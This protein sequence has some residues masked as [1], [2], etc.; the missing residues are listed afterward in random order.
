[1]NT[2]MI[3]TKTELKE[4]TIRIK[5]LKSH[6]K[7]DKRGNWKL[8]DLHY[9]I[10]NS[11]CTFRTKHIAYS[12]ARGRKYEEIEHNVRLGN[13]PNW[14]AINKLLEVLNEQE[15]VRACA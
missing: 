8:Y 14:H 5:D 15:D 10:Y 6:R 9:A 7:L 13:E 11:K 2:K 12:L 3:E 4:L 1:M